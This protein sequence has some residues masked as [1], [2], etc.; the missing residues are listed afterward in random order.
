MKVNI[1]TGKP[2]GGGKPKCLMISESADEVIDFF[3]KLRASKGVIEET[4]EKF[5]NIALFQ[6][7]TTTKRSTFHENEAAPVETP[8]P[9]EKAA[10]AA[11]S[12]A[13]EKPAVTPSADTPPPA[14]NPPPPDP[15]DPPADEGE[16]EI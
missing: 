12:R 7:P 10:T 2:P 3:T 16:D 6:R 15:Q 5:V 9:E 13:K 1:V 8:T 11:K 14:D 4:G